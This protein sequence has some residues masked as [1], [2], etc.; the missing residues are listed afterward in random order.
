MLTILNYGMGNLRSVQN[1]FTYLG[2]P[3]RI[4]EDPAVIAS[5]ERIVLPGVGSFARAMQNIKKRGLGEALQEAANGGSAILGICLGMQL[6]A[7]AGEEDGNSEGLGLISGRVVRMQPKNGLKVPHIGFN[8]L[9]CRQSHG[10]IFARLD[11]GSDF[12]FLH[13]YQ[14][15]PEQSEAIIGSCEYG[16]DVVCAVRKDRIVGVQFHPEK[17]QNNGLRLLRNFL[18]YF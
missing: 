12:Y 11:E 14:F 6:L 3:S 15:V 1:A 10:G 7:T 13:S 18:D 9:N 4:V 17:S 2:T 8:T 16:G 5:S